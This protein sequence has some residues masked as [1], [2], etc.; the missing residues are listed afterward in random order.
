MFY[1][2]RSSTILRWWWSIDSAMLLLILS[3][4]LIGVFLNA[5]AGP[6]VAE[7]IGAPYFH[8]LYK[9][10]VFLIISVLI[11]IG[12][13][14][15]SRKNIKR[16]ALIGYII[17][18]LLL[19]LALFIGVETKGARRWINIFGVFIQPSELI[20]PF[21]TVLI[22]II[23]SSQSE[24]KNLFSFKSW[25]LNLALLL[26]VLICILLILQPDFG[27]TAT[28]SIVT[29]SQF[30]IAGLSMIWLLITSAIMSL[31]VFIAYQSL[32][33]VASRINKF[34]NAQENSNYQV[35]KSL[36]SYLNGG[37]FGK[38]PGEG[39]VKMVLPDSHTDF[40]FAVA[41]EEMGIFFCILIVIIYASIMIKS[42]IRCYQVKDLFVTYSVCGLMM[43]FGM[44]SLFNIGVT[45][46]IFPTKGMTLPFI[47][48][49]GSSMISFAIAIGIYLNLTKKTIKIH[50]PSN[51][52]KVNL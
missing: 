41:A 49:G 6:A 33:H 1:F 37:F 3:L 51:K 18:I 46:H 30:F 26:H 44:Q 14:T 50:L 13:S 25:N 4:M 19:V 15:I 45:L 12:I 21:Y 20:K 11:I 10:L 5:T 17:L 43:Y 36:E 29:L 40:I 47:S 16:L 2:K 39:S 38:G 9:Q 52:V 8:F 24:Q 31:G 7:R 23:L 22:G 32:P 42:V 28:I 48:Y 27:M 34:L 35:T